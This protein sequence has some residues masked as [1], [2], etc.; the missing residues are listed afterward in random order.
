MSGVAFIIDIGLR[1][2]DRLVVPVLKWLVPFFIGKQTAKKE[3]MERGIGRLVLRD[4]THRDIVDSSDARNERNR[5][6][7]WARDSTNSQ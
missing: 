5:L 4:E 6:R 2:V 3:E 7:D 1:L